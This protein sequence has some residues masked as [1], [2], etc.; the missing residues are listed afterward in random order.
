MDFGDYFKVAMH[1]EKYLEPLRFRFTRMLTYAME[2][3]NSEESLGS[4][5]RIL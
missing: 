2:V 1:R 4:R 5:V 3:S